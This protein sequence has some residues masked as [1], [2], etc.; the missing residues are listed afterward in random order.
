MLVTEIGSIS[1][2]VEITDPKHF[3]LGVSL[4][5]QSCFP[6]PHSPHPLKYLE[7]KIILKVGNFNG[8]F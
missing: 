6:I 7:N 4:L 2:R 8:S 5:E 3:S 1:I